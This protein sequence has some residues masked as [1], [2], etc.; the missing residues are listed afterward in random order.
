MQAAFQLFEESHHIFPQLFVHYL[1]RFPDLRAFFEYDPYDP[2]SVER[3]ARWLDEH[4]RGDRKTLAADLEQ[5]NREIGAADAA[6]ENARA[7]GDDKA[8]AI[9]TGQQAG[10]LGGPL[11]TLYKAL[12]AI[13]LAE[14][15]SNQLN[16]PVIPV[17]WI[18]SEDHDFDE[19]RRAF[20]NDA[21]GAIREIALPPAPG[22]R[23][24]MSDRPVPRRVAGMLREIRQALGPVMRDADVLQQAEAAAVAARSWSDWFARLMANWLS[25]YGLVMLDP[26]RRDLRRPLANFWPTVLVR[27]EGIHRETTAAA[28]R[29]RRNGYE[30][31][32][33]LDTN[34]SHLFVFHDQERLALFWQGDTLVDREGRI[35]LT[36]GQATR[37]MREEPWRFSANVVLRPIVQEILLPTLA[38]V[39]GPGEIAYLA[40][41]RHV[42][43]LFGLQMPIIHPRASFTVVTP[44]VAQ[45]LVACS[46]GAGT[47]LTGKGEEA[48]LERLRSVDPVGIEQKLGQLREQITHAYET[49]IDDLQKISPHLTKLGKANLERVLAQVAFL[50]KKAWYHLRK[51]H[52]ALTKNFRA[53]QNALLPA[54]KPQERF[55]AVLPLLAQ[56]GRGL[57]R[58]LLRNAPVAGHQVVILSERDGSGSPAVRTGMPV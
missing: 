34:H 44:E 54:G 12:S 26:M 39:A 6:I 30:P 9:V 10:L 47:I 42:Y 11:Y 25:P 46:V 4:F 1:H 5:F 7:L 29:L 45:R 50:E 31:G 3:R 27:G 22:M 41:M 24:S 40:Q 57:I 18:A 58:Y 20:F 56:C 52:Q 8:L 16:R 19:V 15:A 13:R 49:A 33:E 43:P 23:V 21:K 14:V 32:L 28:R 2:R 38:F 55:H 51:S 17:F 37:L 36:A 53:L 35:R 48:L